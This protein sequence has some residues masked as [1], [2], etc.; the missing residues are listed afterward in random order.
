MRALIYILV[1]FTLALTSCEGEDGARRNS[2]I[3][4]VIGANITL[5]KFVMSQCYYYGK[6]KIM[7]S[8]KSN[9]T[10]EVY[11]E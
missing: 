1:S 2:E 3:N 8:I 7:R 11:H 4:Y 5:S 10:K 6:N 9:G